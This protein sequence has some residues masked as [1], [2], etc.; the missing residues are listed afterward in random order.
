V[1]AVIGIAGEE[2]LVRKH[3]GDQQVVAAPSAVVSGVRAA[4]GT[5]VVLPP[6]S[7][8]V[9]S[10]DAL[11]LIGGG[12]V[13]TDPARDRDELALLERARRAGLPTLGVCRG[14]QLMAVAT[15]GSLVEELGDSHRILPPGTHDL[16]TAPGSVVAGLVPEGRVG[17]L[18]HQ[19]V[20]TYDDRWRCTATA[21]DGVVEAL[22]WGDQDEWPALGVQ[23]H[24]ELDGTG[25]AVFGWLVRAAGPHAATTGLTCLSALYSPLAYRSTGTGTVAP[26]R[27]TAS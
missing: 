18:H 26:A 7:T 19:A 6:G 2:L 1:T 24:P 12:D 27:V 15:G 22:E 8:D 21:P 9:T 17:S 3:F 4:G 23:W 14:L 13:G 20:A 25:P 5:P 16:Q 11:V 10:L